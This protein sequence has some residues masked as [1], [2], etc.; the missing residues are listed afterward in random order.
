[1]T[2]I[3]D[4][5]AEHERKFHNVVPNP[6]P[7][8]PEP[9]P[10]PEPEPTPEPTPDPTPTPGGIWVS[11]LR[12]VDG[13]PTSVPTSCNVSDQNANADVLILGAALRSTQDQ[14]LRAKVVSALEN[15]IDTEQG[16]RWLAIGRNL[17]A[18]IIAADVVGI[19]S[20]PV[21]DWLAS[22]RTKKLAHNNSGNPITIQQS[23][24]ASGSNAS[25]QEGFVC[26][27]LA[28]Y[29]GD[30]ALLEWNWTAFRRYA[31]DRS[32]PHKMASND[33]SW[34]EKPTDPVGIQNKGA[35]KNGVKID[36][37]ISNDMSRGGS[38]SSTPGYT[39]YPWV[40]L[41]GAVPAA[42]ILARAGYPA[43]TVGAS[44][45]KRAAEYLHSLRSQNGDWYDG[46]RSKDIKHLLNVAYGL[47]F[48][49][50]KPVGQGRTTGY[51]DI[52]HPDRASLG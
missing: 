14:A 47:N 22:F 4:A 36:G 25:A 37:A 6:I 38:L 50:N 43:W 30:K 35:V 16:S 24:W 2:D 44:A 31:G 32:S 41:E 26:S 49:G 19:H 51:T 8:T 12:S 46:T 7:P 39:S 27:A 45:L 9:T 42:V 21:Y 20:G 13:L 34:Q 29:T 40:G 5:I 28:A 48:P 17:G 23:A 33:D 18:L 11:E 15:S 3:A 1:M 52:T 10:E